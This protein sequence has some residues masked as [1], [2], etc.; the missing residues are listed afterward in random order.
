MTPDQA[1]A[2]AMERKDTRKCEALTVAGRENAARLVNE[3]R[4]NG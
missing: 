2:T 4:R 1:P 3:A